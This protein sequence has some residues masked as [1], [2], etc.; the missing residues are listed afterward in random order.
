MKKGLKFTTAALGITLLIIA[1]LGTT[2]FADPEDDGT[3]R[4]TCYAE[5]GVRGGFGMVGGMTET[6]GDLV[7]LTTDEIH[8]LRI[9]GFSLAD[10]AEANGISV[11]ALIAAIMVEKTVW[12][13]E[14][15]ADGIITQEQADLM[16]QT[17]QEKTVEA[18]NRTTVGPLEWRGGLQNNANGAGNQWKARGSRGMGGYGSG[19]CGNTGIGN[20]WG[21]ATR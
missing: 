4:T 16:I 12:L 17:M 1:V 20:M 6:V 21:N 13:E 5:N 9:E 2:V 8:D 7:G 14:K 19:S 15:V 11:D 3:Y 10:I 18:V